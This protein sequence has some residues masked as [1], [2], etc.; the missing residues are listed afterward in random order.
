MKM[1][2]QYLKK[3]IYQARLENYS[4]VFFYL[5]F[6]KNLMLLQFNCNSIEITFFFSTGGVI[7]CILL[8]PVGQTNT[9]FDPPLEKKNYV[10]HG[11][12]IYFP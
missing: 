7:K 3:L 8:L 4:G 9:F 11:K 1:Q 12:N 10:Q 6:L 2:L 5:I